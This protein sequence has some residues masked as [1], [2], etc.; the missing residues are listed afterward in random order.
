MSNPSK[1]GK[2]NKPR[3]L[4]IAIVGHT[5]AGKTS[6]LRTLTRD[7]RFGKVSSD[8]GTTR[9]SQS[10]DL[11]LDGRCA[12]R[13]ID[14]PGLEDSVA[15]LEY[16]HDLPGDTRPERM[17]AFLNG[18]EARKTFEQEAKVLRA[19]N[20]MS[21]AAM[22]VID[23]REAPLPKHRAEID[24][25]SGCGRPVMPVLNFMRDAA[26]RSA[27]WHEALREGGL[28]ALVEFDVVAPFIGGEQ[29]LYATLTTLLPAQ[30]A[31]L[32]GVMET[33]AH[34]EKQRRAS[35]CRVIAGALIEVAAMRHPLCAEKWDD[36]MQ[37]ASFVRAFRALVQ[38]RA[39]RAADDLL[40]IY[41]FG[42]NDAELAELP[43]LA[44]R[45][46]DDLF[47]PELLKQ[48]SLRLGK[49]AAV[50]AVMG[51]IVD[52]AL[53][54][55]SLGAAAS[56]GAAIGGA[57]SGGW[58]SAWRKISGR[59][60]G[61]QELTVENAVLAL[62]AQRLLTLTVALMQRGHAA[63]EKM[64]ALQDAPIVETL[65]LEMLEDARAHPEWARARKGSIAI[66][67]ERR[68]LENALVR[69]LT[70]A[71]E[72]RLKNAQHAHRAG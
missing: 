10:T 7:V 1:P 15:L 44:G 64:R 34:Q 39:R 29:Q 41:A 14:T 56:T 13:F 53:A 47:N 38:T 27:E 49:G 17:V 40:A 57:L 28:H 16:L 20:E 46:E 62:L 51:A 72:A 3:P 19:L 45:W 11:R 22:Y 18:P 8:P 70:T 33:L 32:V 52:V 63:Q 68:T 6:L 43:E 24:I 58:R 5:N 26:S 25:L 12:L 67:A 55:V 54:G 48:A 69:E 71:L 2:S 50:G 42:A 31:H 23:T 30:R 37:R 9:A 36:D 60:R 21:D 65:H 4:S 66:S 61:M 59:L 35:A